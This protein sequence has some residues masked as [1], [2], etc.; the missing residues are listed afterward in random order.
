[1]K[2]CNSQQS[3]A[4]VA[5]VALAGG[6]IGAS[7]STAYVTGNG[8]GHQSQRAIQVDGA[9]TEHALRVQARRN[10]RLQGLQRSDTVYSS[11]GPEDDAL[12]VSRF[13]YLQAR[14][15]CIESGFSHPRRF[16]A[17]ISSVLETGGYFGL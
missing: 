1:M 2:K 5:L 11:A 13:E 9:N 10:E 15:W 3:L 17:C 8:Y 16:P 4:L 12:Q 14:L 6:Y 7:V